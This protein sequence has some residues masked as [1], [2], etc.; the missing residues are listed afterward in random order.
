ML[1]ITPELEAFIDRALAEDL[2]SGDPTTD[3]LIPQDILGRANII[4]KAEG[5]LAGVDVAVAIFRRLDPR[6]DANALMSDGAALR[7]WVRETGA[8]GDVVAEVQGP[9]ASILKA[10]RTALN[11]LQHM[12]GVATQVSRYVKAVEGYNVRILDTRKT[13]PGLRALEKYAVTMGGG[14]NHR[15]NMG[16]GVLIKDNHIAILKQAGMTLAEIVQRAKDRAPH[17]LRI[18]VEVED[19][20]MVYEAVD[21]GAEIL[22]LDNMPPEEMAKAVRIVAGRAITEASGGITLDNVREVAAT[23]VDMISIG[24][25]THSVKALDLSLD[26]V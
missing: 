21:A 18:E 9:V 4:P 5:V 12:S 17:S 11:I 16:D 19:L 1:P 22:L 6:L 13:L 7:P 15:R 20:D 3:S 14:R 26:L 25:L 24:A 2:S 10:E 8:E 23:G